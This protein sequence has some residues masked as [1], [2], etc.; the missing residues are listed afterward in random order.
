MSKYI[1]MTQE[2][3][4]VYDRDNAESVELM[5]ELRKQAEALREG[6]EPVEIYTADGIVAEVIQ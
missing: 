1:E 6:N 4:E 5:K 2:Q 3:T